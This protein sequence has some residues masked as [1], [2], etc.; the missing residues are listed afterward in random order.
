[1]A[2]LGVHLGVNLLTRRLRRNLTET[3]LPL[4]PPPPKTL[5]QEQGIKPVQRQ[6]LKMEHKKSTRP[7]RIKRTLGK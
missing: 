4:N 1:T 3:A 2:G 7:K 5:A 6:D